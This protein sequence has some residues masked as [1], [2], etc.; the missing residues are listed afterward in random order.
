MGI[1][2]EIFVEALKTKRQRLSK[3]IIIRGY[4]NIIIRYKV[5]RF[6]EKIIIKEIWAVIYGHHLGAGYISKRWRVDEV[7]VIGLL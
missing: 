1:M 4:I 2:V 3:D 7:L 6:S 5:V